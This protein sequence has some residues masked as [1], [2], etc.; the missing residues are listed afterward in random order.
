MIRLHRPRRRPVRAGSTR[1]RRIVVRAR[2]ACPR[3]EADLSSLIL[4]GQG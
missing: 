1:V 4:Y 2:P 3:E